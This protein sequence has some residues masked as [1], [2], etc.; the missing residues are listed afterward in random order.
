MPHVSV[1]VPVYDEERYVA[2]AIESILCQTYRDFELLVL[3]DGSQDG[4]LSVLQRYA[5]SDDRMRVISRGNKGVAAT[6]RELVEEAEGKLIASMDADDVALPC[7]LERQVNYMREN[8]E[9]VAVGSQ[10]YLIDPQGW[11]LGKTHYPLKHS[12]IESNLLMRGEM[13]VTFTHSAML[14]HRDAVRDVGNYRLDFGPGEDRDLLIRLSEVGRL[15]NL[16]VPL[17]K[18]RLHS[19]GWYN[20]KERKSTTL[21]AVQDAYER[22]SENLSEDV[23]TKINKYY[24]S[25]SKPSKSKFFI[26]IDWSKKAMLIGNTK[27]ALYYLGASVIEHPF[28]VE[29]LRLIGRFVKHIGKRVIGRVDVLRVEEK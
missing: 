28:S 14:M 25:M 24:K 3:D 8:S 13:P 23:K 19:C 21:Q 4:T 26:Y 5:K 10:A 17:V 11:V 12:K 22:R 20:V 6:R 1:I 27:A 15:A 16:P 18:Y 9:C 7:R 2:E 29:T